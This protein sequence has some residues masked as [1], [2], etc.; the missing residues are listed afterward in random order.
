MAWRIITTYFPSFNELLGEG[1]SIN[2]SSFSEKI[3]DISARFEDRFADFDLLKAK[4]ERF[5]DPIEEVS[6][7]LS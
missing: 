5:N 1:K 6:T 3:S 4:V 7:T 2:F